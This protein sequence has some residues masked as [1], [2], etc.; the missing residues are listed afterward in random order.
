MFDAGKWRYMAG[1]AD[2]EDKLSRGGEV[3]CSCPL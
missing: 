2:P 1:S 3:C